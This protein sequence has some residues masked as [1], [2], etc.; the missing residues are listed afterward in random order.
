MHKKKGKF[1]Y[2]ML[3]IDFEKTYDKVD[4]EFLRVTLCEFGFPYTIIALVLNCIT[5]TLLAL[6]WN[7]EIIEGFNLS[8]GLCH[9]D[10]LSPYLFVLCMEKLALLIQQEV[11]NNSWSPV[12]MTLLTKNGPSILH[13]FL[14]M[15]R[16]FICG[17][18]WSST[19]I[20]IGA[21]MLIYLSFILTY[22][23]LNFFI[24]V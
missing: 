16:R 10:P 8:S 15:T 21:H 22:M 14:S 9:R 2:L 6:R 1:G 11:E 18:S 3:K 4:W 12:R 20:V 17:I 23:M 13:L 7:N 19:T 5:S 24:F